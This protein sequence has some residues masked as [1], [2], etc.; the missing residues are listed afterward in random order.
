MKCFKAVF[1]LKDLK[2]NYGFFIMTLI[3]IFYFI[4]LIIFVTISNDK[5]KKEINKIIIA[6]KFNTIPINEAKLKD[7]PVTIVKK[8]KKKKKKIIIKTNNIINQTDIKEKILNINKINDNKDD[9]YSRQNM[10]INEDNSVNKF[11]L[12]SEVIDENKNSY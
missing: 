6:L 3:I 9:I 5:L 12:K 4:S 7:K 1:K 11:S 2:E 8:R 10:Q